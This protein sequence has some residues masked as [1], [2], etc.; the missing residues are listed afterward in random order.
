[1]PGV[2]GTGDPEFGG[3]YTPA[4]SHLVASDETP[5]GQKYPSSHDTDWHVALPSGVVENVAFE[6]IYFEPSPGHR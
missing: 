5:F 6:H 2:A 3:Q 1:M 4:P